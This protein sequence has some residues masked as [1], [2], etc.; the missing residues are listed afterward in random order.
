M[1]KNPAAAVANI[2]PATPIHRA[3]RLQEGDLD[4]HEQNEHLRRERQK[5]D[6]SD[7]A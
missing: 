2:P 3:G 7:L 1:T 4:R 5:R 6:E